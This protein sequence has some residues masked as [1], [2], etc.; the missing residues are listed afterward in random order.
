M[1]EEGKKNERREYFK[2]KPRLMALPP[3]SILAKHGCEKLA[4]V[5]RKS[6]PL[7]QS[8]GL[9]GADNMARFSLAL[10][11][12]Q[13]LDNSV[14]RTRSRHPYSF[15]I[16]SRVHHDVLRDNRAVD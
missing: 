1:L 7:L 15:R 6:L 13:T 2:D 4:G 10:G 11:V 14:P 16:Q 9:L 8:G 5:Q 3:I 12:L